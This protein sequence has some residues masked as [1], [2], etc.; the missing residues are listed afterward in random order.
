MLNHAKINLFPPAIVALSIMVGSRIGL[1]F[2]SSRYLQ[3]A[4]YKHTSFEFLKANE[5]FK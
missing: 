2:L 5:L 1:L 4:T 3:H